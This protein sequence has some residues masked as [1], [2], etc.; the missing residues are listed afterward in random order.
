[1]FSPEKDKDKKGFHKQIKN[2]YKMSCIYLLFVP[3][4]HNENSQQPKSRSNPSVHT[5][6][7]RQTKCDIYIQWITI[8]TY[9]GRE[10][11]HILQHRWT[12]KTLYKW[13]K[14]VTEG[15]LPIPDYEVPRGVKFIHRKSDGGCRGWEEGRWEPAYGI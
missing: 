1:M 11:W 15:Q 14:P 9:K 2:F 13:N 7:N 8:C 3:I 6:M 4:K 12:L 5:C 10:F